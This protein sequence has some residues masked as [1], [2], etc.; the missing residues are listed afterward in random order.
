[1]IQL[2]S[3]SE[4]GNET[5]QP[6]ALLINW[7][8][9][10]ADSSAVNELYHRY[11]VPLIII[12]DTIDEDIC[13]KML[14][15]GADDFIIKPLHPRELHA[16]IS[17]IT[18]RVQRST[19][20]AEQEKEVLIFADWRLYPASRQVFNNANQELQLSAGEYDLLL[21]FLRQPQRVLGREFLLQITK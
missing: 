7:S 4:L 15:A 18:R 2:H 12:S 19:Q 9:F 11:S 13:V 21:A 8:L 3:L 17:A 20:E 1:I 6:S 16:R 5:G 10:K 14:E